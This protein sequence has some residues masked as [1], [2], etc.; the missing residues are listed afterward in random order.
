MRAGDTTVFSEKLSLIM[1]VQNVSN[2]RLAKVLSVDPSLISRW[3]TGARKPP[4]KNNYIRELAAYFSSLAKMEYQKAALFQMMD[5]NLI[6]TL[7]ETPVISD[8]LFD[9]LCDET[10]PRSVFVDE[11]LG[12]FDRTITPS[13]DFSDIDIGQS[14]PV[15]ITQ[16]VEV[17]YQNEGKRQ[18]LIRFFSAV[19]AQKKPCTMLLYSDEDIN[20]LSEDPAFYR[21][22]G[23][24]LK[25]L[26]AKGNRI[27]MI[28]V[29]TRD[30]SS[31]LSTI[32]QWLPIYITGAAIEPYYYPN[33]RESI[34]KRTMFIAPNVAAL[35]STSL[36][37]ATNRV[38]YIYHTDRDKIQNLTEEF[39]SFLKI[40]R[41]LMQVFTGSEI[42]KLSNLLLQLEKQ[43]GDYMCRS[44]TLSA[45]TMPQTLFARLLEQTGV[46]EIQ[47]KTLVA[48]QQA[49]Y[50]EFE[51]SLRCNKYTE[52]VNLPPIK[53]FS[54][55]TV[56][57][58]PQDFFGDII[59]CYTR[60]EYCE[61][62]ENIIRLLN[63]YENYHFILNKRS[64]SQNI[65][66]AVKDEVGVIVSKNDE[67]PIAFTFNQQNM[68]TA[69]QCFLEDIIYR[70]PEKER[71]REYAINKISEMI[72]NLRNSIIKEE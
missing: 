43:P 59:L 39:D 23:A 52:I 8:L 19:A 35:T 12:K 68:A 26:F 28:H 57:I 3:R 45:V 61:H 69:F 14:T 56:L 55:G 64:P 13:D 17:F 20:W 42:S 62:L 38:E 51:C 47:K 7:E 54:S 21:R 63:Q 49:R 25:E 22:A 32:D 71:S 24:L 58:N 53:V 27:K 29:I 16:K 1:N 37:V 50:Q 31:M 41:P 10:S 70:A 5:L 33:Y 44:N 15:G 66:L 60:T 34:F 72:V 18:S 4:A 48:V 30:L 67:S 6:N 65:C 46:N 40:C 2:S 36:S 11:L 9:W